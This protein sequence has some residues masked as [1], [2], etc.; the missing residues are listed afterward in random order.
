M[1]IAQILSEKSV[2]AYEKLGLAPA[3]YVLGSILI[4]GHLIP[5]IAPE[6]T[7]NFL[8]KIPRNQPL[9]QGILALALFWFF[10]L[11]A[12]AG[13]GILSSLRTEI[14]GFENIRPILQCAIPLAFL[15]MIFYVKEFLTAR[16]LGVLGLLFVAPFLSAAYLKEPATRLLI[17][18][19]SYA[20]IFM[21][22][23]WLAKPYLLRDQ[24]NW[25][26]AKPY[27]LPL[28]SIVGLAYGV[29]ILLYAIL[30]W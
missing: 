16:A 3:G 12:P 5:L 6:K 28:L 24:I 8:P 9:G 26:L 30:F 19:W 15:L 11:I 20:V 25:L 1:F 22:F 27:R 4:I 13:N 10:L 29:A 7:R 23:F 21:S 2:H 14:T 17:P 18:I